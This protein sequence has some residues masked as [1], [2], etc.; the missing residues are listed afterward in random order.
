M[1]SNVDQ[2]LFVKVID[3]VY[4]SKVIKGLHKM[5]PQTMRVIKAYADF[6]AVTSTAGNYR[7]LDVAD[8]SP[9]S[10]EEGNVVV[11][12]MAVTDGALLFGG[13]NVT[14][15]LA[16]VGTESTPATVSDVTLFKVVADSVLT[17]GIQLPPTTATGALLSTEL[18]VG[19]T[20]KYL[21]VTTASACSV[22]GRLNV[23]L[24]VV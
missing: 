18:F 15:G 8:D 7:L 3:T 6:T 10:L 14:I 19:N 17:L 24:I 22:S 20:I 4:D 23:V 12:G 16:T 11:Y 13:G 9:V 21:N 2:N 1:S 5:L